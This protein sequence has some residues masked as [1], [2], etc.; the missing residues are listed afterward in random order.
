[1]GRSTTNT[2][3]HVGKYGASK[4]SETKVGSRTFP[5]RSNMSAPME[6]SR[7]LSNFPSINVT[8]SPRSNNATLMG[9]RSTKFACRTM[10]S[11]ALRW[12]CNRML[13]QKNG[14]INPAI[15]RVQ[16]AA[17]IIFTRN[18]SKLRFHRNQR[19]RS[20]CVKGICPRPHF[21]RCP[22]VHQE[23]CGQH[24]WP[25]LWWHHSWASPQRGH[26]V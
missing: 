25:A 12:D 15:T 6:R 2:G 17:A 26:L 5:W 18:F 13:A 1:M 10:D 23:H 16:A 20:E 24:C 8:T 7:L 11:I 21:D 4:I 19:S 3:D 22:A 9:S 14:E